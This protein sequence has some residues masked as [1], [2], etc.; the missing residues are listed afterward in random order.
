MARFA[1]IDSQICANRLDSRESFQGSPT[2]PLSGESRFGALNSANGRFD[3]AIRANRSRVMKIVV[4]FLRID[5]RESPRFAL[6]IARPPK[7]ETC[8]ERPFKRT[9]AFRTAERSERMQ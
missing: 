5:S 8:L 9:V 1:R 7:L 6:P 4:F 2:E 3:E